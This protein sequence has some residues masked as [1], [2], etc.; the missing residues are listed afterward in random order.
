DGLWGNSFGI[1]NTDYIKKATGFDCQKIMGG[2]INGLRG[3][4]IVNNIYSIAFSVWLV[5]FYALVMFLK[6]R[7]AFILPVTPLVALWG[8]MMIA[9]PTFCEF[10]Y[11]FSFHLAL[12]FL[13]ITLFLENKNFK[14]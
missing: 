6:K 5:F 3:A 1:E 10:R 12:P 11:M 2:G 14:I 13:F 8:T 9:A 4:I 7:C